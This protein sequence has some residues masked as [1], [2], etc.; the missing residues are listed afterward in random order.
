MENFGDLAQNI[1]R[2]VTAVC[3]HMTSYP[4]HD[5]LGVITNKY[6][7]ENNGTIERPSYLE[8]CHQTG[9][10]QVDRVEESTSQRRFTERR[11]VFRTVII[12][13]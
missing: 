6:M 7:E 5:W 11:C 10:L 4:K 8:V 9:E 3:D 12:K 2:A 13:R 1:H